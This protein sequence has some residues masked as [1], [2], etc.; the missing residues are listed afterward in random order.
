M[1]AKQPTMAVEDISP[2][3]GPL[4]PAGAETAIGPYFMD[5]GGQ[6]V[7]S[8]IV[9]TSS[10]TSGGITINL[11]YT[12]AA[13][14]APAAFRAGIEQAAALIASAVTDTITINLDIDYSSDTSVLPAGS[15]FGGPSGGLFKT[16][17]TALSQLTGGETVGDGVF[18]ALPA[19]SSVQ[20]QSNV[21]VWNS[22][23]KLWGM[24]PTTTASDGSATFSS[25]INSNLLVGVALHEL[26]HAMGRVPYG[27][28][29][30]ILDLFRFTGTGS[31][32]FDGN[33][34]ASAS[35]YFSL[36]GGTTDLADYGVNSD[37]S[38][39][40]N[41]GVQGATDPFNEFY[42]GGTLQ[43]LT[44]VDLKQLEVLGFHVVFPNST[45]TGGVTI[46]GAATKGQT[47]TASNTLADADGLGTVSYQWKADGSN[48]AGATNGTLLL[49]TAQVGKVITVTASYT[50]GYATHESVTSNGTAAVVVANNP[51]TGNAAVSGTATQGQTLSANT[52]AIADADGLG[53]FSYQWLRDGNSITNAQ[54]STYLLA[55]ADVGHAV[56]VRVSYTDGG[57]TAES[58]TSP[59]TANVA[60]VNDAPTGSVTITGSPMVGQ[61]LTA[62]ASGIADA[63][64][65]GTFSYK[66]Y[67]D[68]AE[69][70]G[71]TSNTFDLT[72]TQ[73]GAAITVTVSYVDGFGANESVTSSGTSSV[74]NVNSSPTGNA[75]ITGTATQ[76]Q[77]LAADTGSIADA[78]GLGAF[79][80]QWL[81]DG[82]AIT[83]ASASTYSLV[84]ADVGHAISVR[85]TYLDGGGHDETLT[86][87]A[88]DSVANLN[89][90]PTG[91]VTISGSAV[92][93]QT[94]SANAG[95][96]A[97]ADGLGAF[98]YQWYADG[99]PVVGATSST[100]KL[101][102]LQAGT[103]VTVTVSYTDGLGAGESVTSAAT[104]IVT[105]PP[106]VNINGTSAAD[107][108]AGTDGADTLNGGGGNDTLSGGWSND[109]LTGGAGVDKVD[110]QEGSDLYIVAAAGD[111]AAAEF[112]DTGTIGSDELRFTATATGTLTIFSGDTGIEKV[113]IGT[114]TGANA[115]RTA[116][117]VLNVNAAAAVNALAIYGNA[118]VNTITGTA[119]NDTLD[120]GAGADKLT[121]G[122]GDDL[123]IVD[124]AKDIVT[125]GTTGG[126][127]TVRA[128]ASFILGANVEDLVL[129]GTAAI[130]GTG[131][132]SVNTITGNAAA[133]VIDGKGG[134]DLLDG[135]GGSDIYLVVS[136]ADHPGA[137]IADSGSS[138][139][140]EVRF[141]A[142]AASTLVLFA[143]DTGIERVT[144]GTGTAAVATTSGTVALNVDA[145]A[146]GNA[147]AISGNAGANTLVGTAF[148]DTID[149]KAGKDILTGGGGADAFVFSVAANAKAVDTI[150][151]FTSGVDSLEFSKAVF[152]GL[153]T[154]AGPLSAAQFWSAAG[155]VKGHDLDDRIIYDT[156]TGTV[157]YDADG[158]G[159]AAAIAVAVIGTGTH[160]NLQFTD[161]FIVN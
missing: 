99:N 4:S 138:G 82:N 160:P 40:L 12:A 115:V 57:G 52:G 120:G 148:D 106:G 155:A 85:V 8:P 24:T 80:Y 105:V 119:F 146:V 72:A 44:K 142:A 7:T 23:L 32:L 31:Y 129:A 126:H 43:A 67:A 50:D 109:T 158:S 86:S 3:V 69:I 27:P 131:N 5:D 41:S 58:L 98:S 87:D 121:G 77:V 95:S 35:S 122:A 51:P 38:D 151:D 30:D 128:S 141:A 75:A 153:G 89:D 118:G 139:S 73:L 81:R 149:G 156:D 132:A 22:E 53:A 140:D 11:Q 1:Y 117:T 112:A 101:T 91:G 66:W 36:N 20:G 56:S 78:D 76:G 63:D 127:D 107:S 150:T 33:V 136:A 88:T 70:A 13:A 154:L 83:N 28:Q 108:I 116:T 152:K 90:A 103:A 102:P 124:N 18:D 45:P 2:L 46:T 111:H 26:T 125:E 60:N 144:I 62:D 71:A 49:G 48:I 9:E 104:A 59:A 17:A 10:I 100:F 157:Y 74:L 34:P 65:L 84:Q 145:S 133:N 19:G 130:N 134:L 161:I 6:P 137:E 94:L 47:L 14:A 123:Y 147:L 114:G 21:A 29:P 97:D 68:G 42:G 37:P 110:G 93:G 25:F 143:G 54:S 159:R 135:A 96:I 113:V 79:S 61:T 16:Y 39:F 64:G 92:S 15:A 55:Q